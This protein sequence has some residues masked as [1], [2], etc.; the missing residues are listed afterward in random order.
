MLWVKAAGQSCTG[1]AHSSRQS[2][3][4]TQRKKKSEKGSREKERERDRLEGENSRE[5][6]GE[7]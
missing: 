1:A 4:I 7:V 3:G 2:S 5:L 6:S